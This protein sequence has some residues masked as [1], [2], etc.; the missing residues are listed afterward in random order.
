MDIMALDGRPLLHVIDSATHY[1]AAAWLDHGQSA[2]EVWSA[3]RRVWVDA[4][5]GSPDVLKV[6]AGTNVTAR[7]LRA[8]CESQ[9][10]YLKV[11]PVEAH[12]QVGL[13]ERHHAV[14]RSIYQKLQHDLPSARPEERLGYTMRA[15]N[16]SVGADG[17]PATLKVFGIFPRLLMPAGPTPT[18][19]ERVAAIREATE[20]ASRAY[21]RYVIK[22]GVK[23]GP[24]PD[25][26]TAARV[27][28]MPVGSL[29]R[30]WREG[31][32]W[33]GPIRIATVDDETV[34]FRN[35]KGGLSR[36]PISVARPA[37]P[38]TDGYDNSLTHD[39]GHA[40]HYYTAAQEIF[41]GSRAKELAEHARLG[42]FQVVNRSE[43]AGERKYHGTFVDTMKS[44]GP[45]SRLVV[46]ATN[47]KQDGLTGAPTVQRYSTRCALAFVACRPDFTGKCRD[48]STA[49]LQSDSTISRR[50][51]MFPS[52]EMGLPPESLLRVVRPLYGLPEAPLHWYSTYSR[53][54]RETLGMDIAAHDPCF[55]AC[56]Q[57]ADCVG[58]V[59]LQVDDATVFGTNSFHKKEEKAAQKFKDKG[60]T[61]IS[62]IEQQQNG[63]K[64]AFYDNGSKDLENERHYSMNQSEY[65]RRIAEVAARGSEEAELADIRSQNAAAAFVAHG[66]RPDLLV[67]V[68]LFSQ[69][70]PAIYEPIDRKRFNKFVQRCHTTQDTVMRFVQLDIQT[71]HIAVFVDASFAS[72]RDGS[73]QVG[74][75]VCLRDARGKC[76]VIHSSSTKSKRVARS[77]LTA[78]I[79]ALLDGF[80][81]GYVLKVWLERLFNKPLELHILTDSRTA[82]H[83]VTTLVITRER[84]LM[85]DL[86]LLR[87]AYENREI[88]RISWITGLSNPADGLT[89]IKHNGRLE[90]LLRSNTILIEAA[91]WI[92]RPEMR[93]N[94]D[95]DSE[96]QILNDKGA[97]VCT[98]DSKSESERNA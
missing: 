87:E 90:I 4:L 53:Y 5:A 2:K 18:T 34:S 26:L 59:L 12:N 78:E 88:T 44:T 57:E 76:N 80:D 43:A 52:P 71:V 48:V 21:A 64:T 81:C 61:A 68:A 9:G 51:Y 47:D 3:F 77:T 95:A 15:L 85:V 89:K 25:V 10:I 19:R 31:E 39:E 8:Q 70:T 6:D 98:S 94:N 69:L 82:Y 91:G 58:V 1:Q 50:V 17:F 83:T 41:I 96:K 14:L 74:Y 36:L 27:R 16:D 32:G 55:Y 38:E 20:E 37:Y 72:N 24:A 7:D 49:F 73:S 28:G 67:H 86:H 93:M 54:H 65:T 29:I 75:I 13:V 60:A 11:V 66:T 62:E 92:D 33:S 63:S 97:T 56:F 40:E 46:C 45:K 35:K 30:V 22:T 79:F 84:R 42:T 23:P